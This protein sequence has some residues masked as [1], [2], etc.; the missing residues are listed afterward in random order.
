[1]SEQ[2]LLKELLESKV[3]I[4]III[5]LNKELCCLYVSHSIVRI[6]KSRKLRWL[7]PVAVMK[8]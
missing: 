4:Q 1:V 2:V 6:V 7:G 3:N 8:N 5:L